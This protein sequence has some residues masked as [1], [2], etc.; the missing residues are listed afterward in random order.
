MRKLGVATAVALSALVFG[1]TG[2]GAHHNV[3]EIHHAP[4]G[5]C[6]TT[7]FSTNWT[8]D[9]HFSHNAVLVVDAGDTVNTAAIG[10]SITVGPFVADTTIHY[11]VFGGGERDYDVPLWNGHG[12]EDFVDE[13][14]EYGDEHGFGWTA[15]G[16]DDPNPF[17]NWLSIEVEGCELPEGPPGTPG[18]EG[19]AGPPGPEGPEGP[20]GEPGV[21]ALGATPVEVEPR[22]TG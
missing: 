19:P 6:G 1:A 4:T 22:F 7:T 18:P 8:E 9:T 12:E 10:E 2:A 13:I 14:N 17:T 20:P 16:V 15:A 21:T 5:D 3:P 11:R